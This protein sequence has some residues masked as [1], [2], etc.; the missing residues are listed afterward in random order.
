MICLTCAENYRS[1]QDGKCGM[2][3]AANGV[4]KC[5]QGEFGILVDT[6]V[7]IYRC[8]SCPAGCNMC[9]LQDYNDAF[10]SLICYVCDNG[11]YLEEGSC[12]S[13]CDPINEYYDTLYQ[14]CLYCDISCKGCTSL[15]ECINCAPDY[16][17]VDGLCIYQQEVIQD[18]GN[19]YYDYTSNACEC[20]GDS[21]FYNETISNCQSYSDENS[22]PL[23]MYW[24]GNSYHYCEDKNCNKCNPSNPK[25][26]LVCADNF[27]VNAEYGKCAR[28]LLANCKSCKTADM[29]GQCEDGFFMQ[30]LVYDNYT[31]VVSCQATCSAG[32]LPYLPSLY[33]MNPDIFTMEQT[34]EIAN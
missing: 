16:Q 21:E 33:Y 25:K 18:C 11:F 29:C 1:T 15:Y 5:E 34:L 31:V 23:N 30:T 20:F 3:L 13:N 7:K 8:N 6:T 10:S 19:G 9:A 27:F 2:V 17:L 12:Y 26:C 14:S 22:S 32:Y 4:F 24:S 28:C